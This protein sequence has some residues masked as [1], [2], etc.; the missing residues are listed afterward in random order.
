[1]AAA[2]WV[3]CS[4]WLRAFAL[5]LYMVAIAVLV[6]RPELAN[7][8]YAVMALA[9]A[10]NLLFLGAESIPALGMPAGFMRLDSDLRSA[11]DLATAAALVHATGVHPRRLPGIGARAA[12]VWLALA[13]LAAAVATQWLANAW[14]WT[15]AAMI[16]CGVLAVAQLGMGAAHAA[17]SAGG[18]AVA[19]LPADRHDAGRVDGV[20]CHGRLAASR[21]QPGG[22]DRSGGMV[23]VHRLDAA[24][25]AVPGPHAAIDA[26]AFAVGR[27]ERGGRRAGSHVRRRVRAR[28]FR[29][30]HAGAV[31]RTRRVRRPAPM[32]DRPD[33]GARTRH[34]RAHVRA[35]LPGGTRGPGQAAKRRRPAD[36]PAA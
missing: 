23:G 19:L 24:D 36:A 29:L 14:W 34:G 31:H 8:L 20:A 32:V 17:A 25:A 35:T 22:G 12:L 16:G 18:G 27:R 13:A 28:Q 26:R 15:Q 1:M 5:L 10:G 33:A 3:R 4:G 11:F 21:Q 9:Q 30:A 2:G 6:A 7:G